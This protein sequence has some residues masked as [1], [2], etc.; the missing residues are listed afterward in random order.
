MYS[1]L[2]AQ[3]HTILFKNKSHGILKDAAYVFH[4]EH[5]YILCLKAHLSMHISQ[6]TI[7]MRTG[8]YHVD[9]P[10]GLLK[11]VSKIGGLIMIDY[12]VHE[13]FARLQTAAGL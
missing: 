5:T 3:C 10:S 1:N 13:G 2:G 7:K 4:T 11:E 12:T 6:Q 9:L 8:S